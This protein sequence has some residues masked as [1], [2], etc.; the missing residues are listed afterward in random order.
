MRL[1]GGG[2]QNAWTYHLVLKVANII[3]AIFVMGGNVYTVISPWDVYYSGKETY[4]TPASWSFFIWPLIHMLI[5]GTCIYQ[6]S[7]RGKEVIIER[8]GWK[9]PLLDFLN[10]MYIYSWTIQE[11]RYGLVFII[12]AVSVVAQI[13]NEVKETQLRNFCDEVFLHLPFSLYHGWTICLVFMSAF[14]AFGVNALTEPADVWTKVAVFGSLALLQVV[15]FSY[16]YS[17]IEGDLPACLAITWYLFAVVVQQSPERSSF[18]HYST[19]GFAIFSLCWVMR[20]L[21]GLE[22]KYRGRRNR[23]GFGEETSRLLGGH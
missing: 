19:L 3:G 21:I 8:I 17:A 9:L 16:A 18:V 15:D 5:L 14:E 1:F 2:N 10:A 12:F 13:Y 11:Y 6:F 20:C 22:L 23:L 4:F 7:G